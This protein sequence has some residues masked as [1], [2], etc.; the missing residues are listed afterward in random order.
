MGLLQVGGEGDF[1]V[2]QGG[3][4]IAEFFSLTADQMRE[5][6]LKSGV[7]SAEQLDHV[8][9]LLNDPKFWAWQAKTTERA[10]PFPVSR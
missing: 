9:G 2:L 4:P 6:M 10:I 5:R 8:L 1:S 3:S 7:Q